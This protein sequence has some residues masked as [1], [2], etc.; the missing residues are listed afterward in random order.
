VKETQRWANQFE[1][2]IDAYSISRKEDVE[3]VFAA[4]AGNPPAGLITTADLFLFSFRKEIIDFTKKHQL[5]GIYPY[6]DFVDLGGLMYY[7]AD[8]REMWR[9]QVALYIHKVLQGTRPA[10]LPVEQPMKFDMTIN[11]KAAEALGI[12]IPQRFSCGQ[13]G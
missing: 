12:Q 5:L 8:I 2:S 10:D 3:K 7:G 13:I 11:L 4:I 1:I 6:Q 9:R